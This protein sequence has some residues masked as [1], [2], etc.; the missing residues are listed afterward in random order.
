MIDSKL[1]IL[2]TNLSYLGLFGWLFA[3]AFFI[4][5][6]ISIRHSNVIYTAEKINAIKSF[7]KFLDRIILT[8]LRLFI[9]SYCI[10]FIILN[11]TNHYYSVAFREATILITVCIPPYFWVLMLIRLFKKTIERSKQISSPEN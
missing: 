8:T 2:V 9:I 6:E 1:Q 3:L 11:L 4:F 10:I 5:V 7:I